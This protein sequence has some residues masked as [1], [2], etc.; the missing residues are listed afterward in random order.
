MRVM[1]VIMMGLAAVAAPGMIG[2]AGAQTAGSAGAAATAGDAAALPDGQGA[3]PGQVDVTVGAGVALVPSYEGSNDYVVIPAGALRGT[4]SGVAFFSRGTKLFADV[5]RD[6]GAVN[7]QFGPLVAVNFNRSGRIVDDRVEALGRRKIALEL[8]GFAGL[9]KTGVLTSA[10]DTLG[11]SVSY[12]HDVTGVHGSYIV[13]PTIEYGT[14][15]SRKAYVGVSAS[16][17]IVG[18]AYARRY[19]AVD[20]AGAGRSGLPLFASPRGGFKDYT[21]SGLASFSLS[22]DLRRGFA[23][24][25]LGSYARLQGDFARSPITSVAGSRRQLFGALGVGYTF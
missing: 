18:D 2:R 12:R 11:A 16:A 17:T 1:S 22:G 7:V 23:L 21:L 13:E 3:P 15:L 14:P 10:Y 19:F 8:G 6:T 20:A 24:F 4:L 25:A 5:V 9:S